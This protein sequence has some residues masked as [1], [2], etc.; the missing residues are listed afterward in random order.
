MTDIEKEALRAIKRG[1]PGL[2]WEMGP[3][4]CGKGCK[5]YHAYARSIEYFIQLSPK[6]KHGPY[7]EIKFDRPCF[8]I[9]AQ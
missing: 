8:E 3:L 6:V 9:E 5:Q 7:R 4:R 1:W 2:G